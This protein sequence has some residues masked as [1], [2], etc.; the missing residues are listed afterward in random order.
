MPLS[1]LSITLRRLRLDQL[2]GALGLAFGVFW[3]TGAACVQPREY[4]VQDFSGA[5]G[6]SLVSPT[7]TTL[8]VD[9]VRLELEPEP[10]S[11][12]FVRRQESEANIR[13]ALR[14]AFQ[15]AG[16][17]VV[18][19]SAA[20]LIVA[21][22]TVASVRSS[23]GGTGSWANARLDVVAKH[24]DRVLSARSYHSKRRASSAPDAFTNAVS[25]C[26]HRFNQ[27]MTE[28]FWAMRLKQMAED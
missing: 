2:A 10:R 24:G 5:Y 26:V 16:F 20:A 25:R 14:L 7:S 27:E 11:A 22:A 17:D 12:L 28:Q 13:N 18:D 1:A 23:D 8:F 3:L 19:D 6:A 4:W 21:E 15:A 9:E